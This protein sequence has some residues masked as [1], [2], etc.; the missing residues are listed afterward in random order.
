MSGQIITPKQSLRERFK[1]F[2]P[3]VKAALI[4]VG[5]TALFGLVAWIYGFIPGCSATK[6]NGP[7]VSQTANASAGSTVYQAAG[8]ITVNNGASATSL[9]KLAASMA[10]IERTLGP[11]LRLKYPHG[12]VLFTA[13]EKE[14]VIPFQGTNAGKVKLEW[15]RPPQV[16]LHPDA[17]ELALPNIEMQGVVSQGSRCMISRHV[18]FRAGIASGWESA[19]FI[20]LLEDHGSYVHIVLGF[21]NS[22]PPVRKRPM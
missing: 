13:T 4:G 15:P 22:V 8:G 10:R 9:E 5:G 18:G 11:D 19:A 3:Q 12:F 16:L 17:V 14:E 6:S 2:S 21:T 7:T 1:V 20:E